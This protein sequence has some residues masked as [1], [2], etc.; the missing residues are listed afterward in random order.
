MDLNFQEIAREL[1][2]IE[3]RFTPKRKCPRISRNLH[4][5]L[6]ILSKEFDCLGLPTV[7]T[8]ETLPEI[9]EQVVNSARNLIQIHR[10][11]IKNIK[12]KNI[13]KVS[14]EKRHQE[15]QE[16]LQHCKEN[17]RKIQQ[18][19]KSLENTNSILENQLKSLKNLEKTHQKTL[20][21]TKRHLLSKQRHLEL[22]I[23]NSQSEI[24][25]LKQICGQK[26]PSKDEIALKM[27]QKFK[28]N[29]EIY[30][31]TIRALQDNNSALLQEVFNLKEEILLGK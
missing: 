11:S 18:N 8:D 22:E 10:N 4:E 19:C 30:K 14:R 13:E 3:S 25:R 23:K 20:D 29:E 2:E 24:D 15:L 28:I 27:I 17:C 21:Q 6:E 31:E 12:D 9:L 1:E 7:K 16:N 5:N 26:L